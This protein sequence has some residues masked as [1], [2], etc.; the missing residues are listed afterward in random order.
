[1][2]FLLG[3]RVLCLY[4]YMYFKYSKKHFQMCPVKPLGLVVSLGANAAIYRMS[5]FLVVCEQVLGFLQVQLCVCATAVNPLFIWF[6]VIPS[7]T[8]ISS[9]SCVYLSIEI[10]ESN[11]NLSVTKYRISTIYQRGGNCFPITII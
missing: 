6:I 3:C 4:L 1:M 11:G 2:V 8:F 10:S 7:S 5:Q 9:V